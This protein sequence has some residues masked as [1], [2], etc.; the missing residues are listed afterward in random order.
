MS[1]ILGIIASSYYTQA[2]TPTG[3]YDAL[4]SYTVPSG[5][6]TSI[7]FDGIPAGYQHLQL[8]ITSMNSY[9]NDSYFI[10]F[11]GDAGSNYAWHQLYAN[12][13]AGTVPASAASSQ[14]WGL[15]GT[16]AAST[17]TYYTGATIINITDYNSINKYKTVRTLT[18]GDANGSGTVKLTSAL[19]MNTSAINRITIYTENGN[20]SQNSVFSLYGVKG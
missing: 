2:F 6:T 1:P 10:R 9:A 5:G 15:T 19:W 13:G 14:T 16:A 8:R 3:S 7:T 11:N 12:T 4:A 20:S 18:G 17:S